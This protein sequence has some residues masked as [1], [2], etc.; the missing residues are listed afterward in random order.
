MNRNT[1][2][3]GNP[4]H[5]GKL[6]MPPLFPPSAARETARGAQEYSRPADDL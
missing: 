4:S 5:S 2:S 1:K 3:H 6:F